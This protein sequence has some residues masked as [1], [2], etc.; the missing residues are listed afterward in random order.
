MVLHLPSLD[1]LG[2]VDE[3]VRTETP[4]IMSSDKMVEAYESQREI[5]RS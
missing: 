5:L 1:L 2:D 4:I 3:K